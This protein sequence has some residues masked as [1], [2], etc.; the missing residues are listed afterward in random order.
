M[1]QQPLQLNPGLITL[2]QIFS[3]INGSVQTFIVDESAKANVES[4]AVI[5]A[6]VLQDD[7]PV[8]GVNT[9]F[10]KLAS[11]KIDESDAETLQRNLILSHCAGVGEFTDAAVVRLMMILKVNS[12]ARGASGVRWKLIETI[13]ALLNQGITCLLYTSPSPRDKRQ[14]RMPSSA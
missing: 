14:S 13:L 10:G 8:Y 9:G 5:V 2:E 7:A 12:L 6:Q 11:V 4:S 1:A 3:V